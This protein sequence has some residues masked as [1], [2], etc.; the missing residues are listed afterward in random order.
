MS[1]YSSGNREEI[2]PLQLRLVEIDEVK[3]SF[4]PAEIDVAREQEDPL[5]RFQLEVNEIVEHLE[6]SASQCGFKMLPASDAY[7]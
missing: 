4:D 1:R 6:P 3:G 2:A 5:E 7:R